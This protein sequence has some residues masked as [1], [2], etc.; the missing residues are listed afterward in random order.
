MSLRNELLAS[1]NP[2]ALDALYET[3]LAHPSARGKTRRRWSRAYDE[4]RAY[5]ATNKTVRVRKPA[6]PK[7]SK[8]VT[9]KAPRKTAVRVKKT[10]AAVS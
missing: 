9:P 4:R 3:C 1:K 10:V 8:V 5:F 2:K 6:A 7:A